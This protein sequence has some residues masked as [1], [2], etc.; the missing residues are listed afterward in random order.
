MIAA[1]VSTAL[2][3]AAVTNRG[4]VRDINEDSVSIGD[5]LLAVEQSAHASEVELSSP[6]VLMIADGMGGHAR[7]DYASRRTLEFL[8]SDFRALQRSDWTARIARANIDLFDQM[9]RKPELSAM[10]T[11]LVGAEVTRDA[12]TVFNVGDSRAYRVADDGLLQVSIDDVP[13]PTG[14]RSHQITQCLGG[15]LFPSQISPH[16]VVQPPLRFGEQLLFCSDGLTDTV[17]DA[18][19]HRIMRDADGPEQAAWELLRRALRAGG[20]DNIS[21]LAVWSA[22]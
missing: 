8:I 16:V 1:G 11:T 12:V 5:R 19:V 22:D 14:R 4:L 2:R 13:K 6:I 17:P 21:I 7:G 20:P 18:I 9:A 3:I 10:G 15:R